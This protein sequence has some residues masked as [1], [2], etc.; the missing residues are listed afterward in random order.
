MHFICNIF[1]VACSDRMGG[2]CHLC[3]CDSA[4]PTYHAA[5]QVPHIT[6]LPKS[7]QS[8]REGSTKLAPRNT[9]GSNVIDNGVCLWKAH[10]IIYGSFSSLFE[11]LM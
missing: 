6:P 9:M 11:L 10:S 7:P 5:T 1:H 2:I 3:S 8:Q 4:G